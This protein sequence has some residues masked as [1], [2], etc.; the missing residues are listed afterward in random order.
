MA[1]KKCVVCGNEL[2]RRARRYCSRECYYKRSTSKVS[3]LND[4]VPSINRLVEELRKLGEF[5]T[6]LGD[7][8]LEARLRM[9]TAEDTAAWKHASHEY[10]QYRA[11]LPEPAEGI[12]VLQE[13]LLAAFNE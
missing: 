10:R 3:R 12:S 7:A 8:L 5:E 6:P 4:D 9:L 11:Q 1:V 13:E 2:G